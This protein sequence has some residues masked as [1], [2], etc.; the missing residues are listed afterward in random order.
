MATLPNDPASKDIFQLHSLFGNAICVEAY[1]T[2]GPAQ[3]FKC[4]GVG[5]FS[6]HCGHTARCV[7]CSGQHLTKS[8]TKTPDQAP[9]CCN[10]G[11]EHTAYYRKCPV[12]AAEAE[13]I[14]KTRNQSSPKPQD[15]PEA[16]NQTD[17]SSGPTAANARTYAT[18]T[19]QTPEAS[20]T[21]SLGSEAT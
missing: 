2:T 3:C 19:R 4:Q 15:N 7:K 20:P 12:Y 17:M 5:H 10:C 9:K 11:E 6:A 21:A 13:R 14:Q 18:V 8:Y 16:A 1:K